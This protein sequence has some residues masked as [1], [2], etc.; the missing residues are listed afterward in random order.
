MDHEEIREIA[1]EAGRE[2]SREAGREGAREVLKALGID[3][4]NPR[5]A[6]EDFIFLRQWRKGSN[7][8]KTR[9][10]GA[11]I[12]VALSAIAFAIWTG[13]KHTLKP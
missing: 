8:M 7:A 9:V 13:I 4:E 11:A 10:M 2:G 12:T 5:E 1:R 6:Q 3:A